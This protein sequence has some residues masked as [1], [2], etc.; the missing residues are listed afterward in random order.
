M[1]LLLATPTARAAD[2]KQIKLMIQR[3]VAYLKQLQAENGSWAYEQSGMTSLAALTLLE[4]GVPSTDAS[5]QS[6]ATYVRQAAVTEDRTYSLALAILFLDRLGDELD[7]A[8]V[9]GMAARL[10]AGQWGDGG[11]TYS[12]GSQVVQ[13][14]QAR[15]LGALRQGG[16]GERRA[17]KATERRTRDK[18]S[19]AARGEIDA[20]VK[21]QP[22]DG[23][24]GG[25]ATAVAM[26]Q[27]MQ[28]DNSNTQ[29]ALLGLWT[30]R[31]YGV[32]V[33]EALAR[34]EA[35]F[36]KSQSLDGGWGYV[37]DSPTKDATGA[38]IP[39]AFSSPTMV[40]AGLLG[41]AMSH[42]A[43]GDR[44]GDGDRDNPAG[45]DA[46]AA[47]DITKDAGVARALRA[48]GTTMVPPP[49]QN[50]A[51]ARPGGAGFRGG[52]QPPGGLQRPGGAFPP[53]G[54]EGPN[55][56]GAPGVRRMFPAHNARLYYFL[57]S[58]ERVAVAYGLERI[59]GKDWY[60]YGADL[61]LAN[62][63]ADGSWQGA[64]GT[65]GADTCFALLFLSRADLAKDLSASL[66]GK[67]K[68]T[69][70]LRAGVGFKGRESI[71]PIRSPFE[72]LPGDHE[73]SERR[74]SA[75]GTRPP[76]TARQVDAEVAKLSAELINAPAAR[77]NTALRRLRDAK[78]A[79]NTLALAY[80]IAQLGSDRKKQVRQALAE[81]LA[82]LKSSS[83]LAYMDDDDAEL[84]RGAA[85][86]C[87]MKDDSST[88]GRL[89]DLLADR[90]RTVERAAYAALKEL[91]KQ[92]FGPA[93]DATAADKA[94]A[95]KKWKAWW[96]KQG[97]K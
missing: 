87:A 28:S 48:L 83:L 6:A 85:L 50:P 8:L 30:A 75:S 72:N 82:N 91:T 24:G 5:I 78:G 62:Q 34:V 71:K 2:E 11:W 80:A 70:E 39:P 63:E 53:H 29:F 47:P 90:E 19:K 60:K 86:A 88:V 36:R 15:L 41:L 21:G 45:R 44:A 14:Q 51:G 10:L 27:G 59:E 37:I 40:C 18:L 12:S 61:L 89:I 68:D 76:L 49:A 79:E 13:G 38:V 96:K 1:A 69:V 52:A 64:H 9:E 32:P 58:L 55:R 17:P 46:G 65:Y 56:A 43:A 16:S 33:D 77:W 26:P 57:W 95:V 67:V 97:E 23:G 3:G 93:A 74:P 54:A 22:L 20:I 25:Q 31:R 81:R 42:V 73:S 35:R 92:D 7:V 84:R 4:C 66:R 94:E